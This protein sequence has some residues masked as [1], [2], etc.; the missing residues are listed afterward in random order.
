MP[1]APKDKTLLGTRLLAVVKQAWALHP[2]PAFRAWAAAY[3]YDDDR[4]PEAAEVAIA[5][6]F[7]HAKA[8]KTLG[9]QRAAAGARYAATAALYLARIRSAPVWGWAKQQGSLMYEAVVWTALAEEWLVRAAATKA[10]EP[11]E[12]WPEAPEG[13]KIL[14]PEPAKLIIPNGVSA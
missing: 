2:D 9:A 5:D 11:P 12:A 14:T 10:G 6:A 4:S 7:R 8:A 1:A 13:Q 3:V